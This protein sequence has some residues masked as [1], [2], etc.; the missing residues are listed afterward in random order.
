[1]L[2]G[3]RLRFREGI[4][5]NAAK[6]P[7]SSPGGGNEVACGPP[8]DQA[9][10]LDRCGDHRLHRALGTS[11]RRAERLCADVRWDFDRDQRSNAKGLTPPPAPKAVP[12]TTSLGTTTIVELSRGDDVGPP[13]TTFDGPDELI[14][15]SS[16]FKRAVAIVGPMTATLYVSSTAP[17]TEI[18]VQ[19]IDEAPAGTR[20]YLQR[21]MLR[22]SHRALNRS[23]SDMLADGTIYRPTVHTRT[24]PQSNLRRPIGISSRCFRWSRLPTGSSTC[25]Q[26]SHSTCSG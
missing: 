1:M 18:F 26:G 11:F 9:F 12:T 21:G 23:L 5:A 14:Y 2:V 6:T 10:L 15:R 17:D 24:Q 13:V 22:A 19:L 16:K 3:P 20:Y 4:R 7:R 25:N 8:G